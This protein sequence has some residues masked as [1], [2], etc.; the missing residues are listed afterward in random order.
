MYKSPVIETRNLSIGYAKGVALNTSIN[1]QLFAGEL[2]ALLGPNGAGKST[3]LRTLCG[4]QPAT[5]GTI[6]LSNRLLSNYS[7]RELSRTIG[8]VLTERTNAGGI[9][10]KEM[11]SLGRQPYTGF[12]GRLSGE[13]TRMVEE[14][15]EAAGIMNKSDYYVSEL[16]DG[17]RQKAMIAKALAQQCP[18]IILDEPTAFLDITSKIETMLLL[19]KLVS[20]QKKT[21]L[22]STHDLEI[23]LQMSD[24]LLLM[25]QRQPVIFGTPETLIS[26]GTVSAFFSSEKIQFDAETG[27]FGIISVCTETH[28]QLSYS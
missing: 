18:V 25:K 22:L 12:L 20:E 2:T 10:V 15:I 9:T 26:D 27:K 11:V 1:L 16:S 5:K 6:L 13:D 3:L 17:E 24:K 21:I 14:S 7:R 28:N 19:K 4:F 8:V 23:A